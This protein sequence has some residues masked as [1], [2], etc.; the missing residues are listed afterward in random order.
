[1]KVTGA[2]STN[3]ATSR[4]NPATSPARQAP[5]RRAR[6]SPAIRQS[7]SSTAAG[8]TAQNFTAPATPRAAPAQASRAGRASMPL[9]KAALAAIRQSRFIQGSSSSV[10]AAA[11]S[12]G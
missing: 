3:G 10:W 1:M 5:V 12:S 9:L 4:A 2:A 8:T 7:T 11:M 6:C